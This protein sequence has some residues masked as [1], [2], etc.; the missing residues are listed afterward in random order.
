MPLKVD[1]KWVHALTGKTLKD[2][3]ITFYVDGIKR[4]VLVNKDTYAPEKDINML[5]T[6]FGVSGPSIINISREVKE[7]LNEG[8]VIMQLDLF[9]DK[10]EKQM[11]E[12][13]LEIFDRN[14]NRKLRNILNAIYPQSMLESIFK[15]TANNLHHIDM[16]KEVHSITKDERKS[17]IKNLKNLKL[18]V[19]ALMG[20]D[21]AIVADGGLELSEVNFKDMSL[22]LI[23]NLHVTGDILNISRPSGGYS[24]Q[25]CWSTGY[26]AGK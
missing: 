5:C 24:L 22:N 17:M 4:K 6:H 20:Y 8:E 10:D 2:L 11:D 21:K 15:D 3:K 26:A 12:F 19:E 9:R 23:E 13:L 18:K 14:K 16:D 7:W 1:S 25:L